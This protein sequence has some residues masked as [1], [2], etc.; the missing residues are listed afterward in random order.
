MSHV[1]Y[2]SYY[3]AIQPK[4]LA[5]TYTC[6][7]TFRSWHIALAVLQTQSLIPFPF[8]SERVTVEPDPSQSR[9]RKRKVDDSIPQTSEP[10]KNACIDSGTSDLL[11]IFLARDVK[12]IMKAEEDLT[13]NYTEVAFVE[14]RTAEFRV[15]TSTKTND[16]P[17]GIRV[18]TGKNHTIWGLFY[19]ILS[20][21]SRD[22]LQ[23]CYWNYG[24]GT[25]FPM[26]IAGTDGVCR[27][28]CSTVAK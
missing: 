7:H 9:G 16:I 10:Y 22:G 20:K 13:D 14:C 23:P 6:S 19:D 1:A 26:A 8:E 17:F 5:V 25:C 11:F 4:R 18:H 3:F 27:A 21:I 15:G 12:P 28:P 24:R 2:V